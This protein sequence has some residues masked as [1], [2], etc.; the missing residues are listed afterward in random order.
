MFEANESG[1][2][3]V[4]SDIHVKFWTERVPS[5]HRARPS[6][7]PGCGAAACPVSGPLGLVGHGVRERQV[8][9]PRSAGARGGLFIIRVR[10]YRCRRCS[11]VCIVLPR[12]VVRRRHFGAGAIGWALFLLGCE[13]RSSRQIRDQVG[14]FGAPEAGSWVTVMRWLRAVERGSLFRARVALHAASIQ[15]RAERVAMTLVSFALPH[16]ASLPLG[17]QAFAGAEAI[18]HAA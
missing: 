15:Q 10:R 5:T 8:R 7:C 1:L 18:A 4:H 9:G 13:R 17:E 6:R 12:G 3:V 16:L 11:S 2:H 14:G